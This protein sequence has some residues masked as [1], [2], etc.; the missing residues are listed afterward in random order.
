MR[1]RRR[2]PG[3]VYQSRIIA[4]QLY[5]PK[6]NHW[7]SALAKY[8]VV[9]ICSNYACDWRVRFRYKL[10]ERVQILGTR[11]HLLQHFKPVTLSSGEITRL[12]KIR[13]C[14]VY[15]CT[16]QKQWKR[17]YQQSFSPDK[18][19][20]SR[21]EGKDIRSFVPQSVPEQRAVDSGHFEC[22]L[23]WTIQCPFWLF[24]WCYTVAFR[25]FNTR[26]PKAI[27]D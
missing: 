27:R 26:R 7:L 12:F 10:R 11:S 1:V 13:L 3:W 17:Q 24:G 2:T 25:W 5:N 21:N 19:G 8:H 6:T 18:S 20:L 15:S 22:S 14:N 23:H 9:N 4:D 16:D